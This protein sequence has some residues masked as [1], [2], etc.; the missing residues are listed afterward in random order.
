M[1]L[2]GISEERK[3]VGQVQ[4]RG[5]CWGWCLWRRCCRCR[6]RLRCRCR[7][8]PT[9]HER[10]LGHTDCRALGLLLRRHPSSE[11]Y[12]L[13]QWR[14]LLLRR[15]S[16][17]LALLCRCCWIHCH[18]Y[19]V[20]R[21]GVLPTRRAAAERRCRSPCRCQHCDWCGLG[22]G[23]Q[24]GTGRCM[25]P[26]GLVSW[27]PHASRLSRCRWR[28]LAREP[29]QQRLLRWALD[30]TCK[31]ATGDM[32]MALSHVRNS[33]FHSSPSRACVH[34]PSTAVQRLLSP[35]LLQRNCEKSVPGCWAVSP[36]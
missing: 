36:R 1:I 16:H 7:A 13:R 8:P 10:Q 26:K 28:L 2:E 4:L 35:G 5:S 12:R 31:S 27:R 24:H 20:H 22:G 6:R 23:G 30:G 32:D 9:A 17:K 29:R 33:T 25:Q 21:G 15:C 19:R 11:W 34:C 3:A 14:I 18:H